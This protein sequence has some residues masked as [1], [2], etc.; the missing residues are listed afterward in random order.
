MQTKALG[1]VLPNDAAAHLLAFRDAVVQALSGSVQEV[2]LF[3]S[4]AR[5]DAGP[6]SD[7]DVAVVLTGSLSADRKVRRQLTDAAW[8]HVVDGYGIVPIALEVDAL[9][10]GSPSRTELAARVLAEG[11][12]VG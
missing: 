2:V 12:R 4:R 9:R 3:G 6:D 7:Y 5:G 10:P 1:E 11:V 8:E